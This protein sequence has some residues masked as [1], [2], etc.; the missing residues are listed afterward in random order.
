M[1]AQWQQYYWNDY[2]LQQQQHQL[3]SSTDAAQYTPTTAY[4]PMG[5]SI[6][7]HQ[8]HQAH[9]Y[10]PPPSTSPPSHTSPP[11]TSPACPPPPPPP[12]PTA[13][14][15]HRH[16]LPQFRL[17]LQP[18]KNLGTPRSPVGTQMPFKDINST[19]T[20]SPPN[21][22]DASGSQACRLLRCSLGYLRTMGR[23]TLQPGRSVTASFAGSFLLGVLPSQFSPH[24]SFRRFAISGWT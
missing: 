4:G 9:P 2:L 18:S 24:I 7:M 16:L 1:D 5:H 13:S 17:Q 22:P 21:G 10:T 12:L 20:S 11:N 3:A 8:Q 19:V 15:L 23:R 6:R 14:R